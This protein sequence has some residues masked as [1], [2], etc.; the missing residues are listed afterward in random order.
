TIELVSDGGSSIDSEGYNAIGIQAIAEANDGNNTLC[1]GSGGDG[2]AVCPVAEY[3]F[4]PGYLV[5]NHFFDDATDPTTGDRIRTALT[6]VPCSEDFNFQAPITTVVQFL[7]YNEFEQRFS[8]SR[9]VTC[10]LEILLSD[11]GR[12]SPASHHPPTTFH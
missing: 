1:L 2:D 5:M 8:T 7:V 11:I 12:P 6:L 9:S 4:C 10:F 3:N